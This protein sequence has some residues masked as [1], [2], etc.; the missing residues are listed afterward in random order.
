MSFVY[1]IDE[2]FEKKYPENEFLLGR[3]LINDK[4]QRLDS[5]GNPVTEDG[6]RRINELGQLINDDG[7]AID[8]EGYLID[9]KG[10]RLSEKKLPFL[11][12][13]GNPIPE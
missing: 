2:N 6:T 5:D 3:K 8:S 12:D 9:E 4:L 7:E 10:E 1:N 13:D 11:D